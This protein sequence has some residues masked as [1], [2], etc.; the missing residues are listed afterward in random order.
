[1]KLLDTT[2]AVDHLRG[3]QP[4]VD[5][6]RGLV[7][8]SETLAASEILRFE[9]VAGVRDDELPAL[10]QFFSAVSWVAIGED[11]TRAAGE[12]ARTYRGANSGI[13]DA[14]YL[15]AATALLLE[16]DLLTTNVRHFPM[17]PGLQPPY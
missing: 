7:E 4:A 17:L 5:L 8:S 11:V 13:D 15:I 16:A 12:L 2:I 9:L 1:V 10:E 6:L 14:D 3:A